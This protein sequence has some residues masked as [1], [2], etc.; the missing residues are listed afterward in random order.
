MLKLFSY[1]KD[2]QEKYNL[3]YEAL[4]KQQQMVNLL[5]EWLN[6]QAGDPHYRC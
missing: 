1:Q 3:I 2:P 4:D 6:N 5:D